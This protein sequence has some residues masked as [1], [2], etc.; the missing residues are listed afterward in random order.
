MNKADAKLIA[1]YVDSC[2]RG[3]P[4]R[5]LFE[6]IGRKFKLADL[7]PGLVEALESAYKTC[8]LVAGCADEYEQCGDEAR[9]LLQTLAKARQLEEHD[10]KPQ[11]K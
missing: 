8:T 5:E 10:D 6:R 11:N 7:V 4:D 3:K 2:T 1:D 9:D